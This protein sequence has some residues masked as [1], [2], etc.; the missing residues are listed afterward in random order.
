MIDYKVILY[1][2]CFGAI[3][4]LIF[5]L[6]IDRIGG[7]L[8]LSVF[9]SVFFCAFFATS[10]ILGQK[11]GFQFSLLATIALIIAYFVSLFVGVITVNQLLSFI[12][13]SFLMA[14]SLFALDGYLYGVRMN[15]AVTYTI[16]SIMLII[17]MYLISI[18]SDKDTHGSMYSIVYSA[19]IYFYL[20]S[21]AILHHSYS[22]YPG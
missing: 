9:F 17:A 2:L 22:K 15:S 13:G 21:S 16:A 20:Q 19:V 18:Y 7:G 5:F 1:P 4:A 8:F 14:L 10:L 6:L 12:A 3:S 11:N